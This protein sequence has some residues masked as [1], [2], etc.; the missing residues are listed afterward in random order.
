MRSRDAAPE[1]SAP[2]GSALTVGVAPPVRDAG[3]VSIS[4]IVPTF[5]RPRELATCL[6]ALAALDYPADRYEVIVVDDGSEPPATPIAAPGRPGLRMTWLRQPN[7]GPAAARNLGARHATG[8]VLAFTDDDCTPEPGWLAALAAA[9]AAKPSALHGGTVLNALAGNRWAVASQTITDVIVPALIAAGSTLRFVTS[10]NLA[11]GAELFRAVG[12]FDESFR[13]AEDRELCHRWVAAGRPLA[14]APNAVVLHRHDLAPASYWR[15]HFGYGRGAYR[16]HRL[17]VLQGAAPY[18]PNLA[19][20]AETFR[21]P[22]A[23][24]PFPAAL[25]IVGPLVMWQLANAAGYLWQRA[26]GVTPR[27][28]TPG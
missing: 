26:V 11:V 19:L 18:R 2:E 10:N 6:G 5:D 16:F 17:R 8:T 27:K 23:T 28:P 1:G 20:L 24:L 3:V 12:G 7:R 9:V 21:R 25:G 14:I 13:A 22:F 4:V 15:Q